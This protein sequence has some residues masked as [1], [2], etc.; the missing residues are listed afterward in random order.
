MSLEAVEVFYSYSVK[1]EK[2]AKRLETHLRVL[3]QAHYLKVWSARQVVAGKERHG[4]ISEHFER[5]KIILML[6]S[7]DFFVE[8]CYEKEVKRALE[9]HDTGEA[10]VIPILLRP[11]QLPKGLPISRLAMLP[12]GGQAV[13]LWRSQDLAFSDIVKAIQSAVEE[14]R[15]ETAPPPPPPEPDTFAPPLPYFIAQL[16]DRRD[17]KEEL[18]AALAK[19][20]EEMQKHNRLIPLVCLVHGGADESLEGFKQR[21]RANDIYE[22]LELN[23]DRYPVKFID[24]RWPSR[25]PEIAEPRQ[26]LERN[27]AE[28]VFEGTAQSGRQEIFNLLGQHPGPVL[29][30]YDF[31]TE[32]WH[33]STPHLIREFLEFWNSLPAVNSRMP[34]VVG[35]F[36]SH[37]KLEG[38]GE[39]ARKVYQERND[40][41]R[42]FFGELGGEF[43]RPEPRPYPNL[44]GVVLKELMPV[45]KTD[46]EDWIDDSRVFSQFCLRHRPGFCNP[47]EIARIKSAIRQLY[48]TSGQLLREDSPDLYIPMEALAESLAGF[49][50]EYRCKV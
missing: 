24:L 36:F 33:S 22:L 15:G 10:R 40:E 17:Q 18:Y 30:S 29:L 16:C 48:L 1:D 20:R 19:Q 9:K 41:A 49:L 13:T 38:F 42:R 26:Y 11:C 47:A 2:L 39:Q 6:L 44:C 45:R 21:L 35:L 32:N 4:E 46:V 43:G 31:S 5:A 28:H 27:L 34:L 3:E 14:I 12:T 8:Y 37:E 23:R 50:N 7:S 25:P